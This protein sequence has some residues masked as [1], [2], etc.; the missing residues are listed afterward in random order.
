ML[1]QGQDAGTLPRG[2]RERG[3]RCLAPRAP[4]GGSAMLQKRTG[5]HNALFD[6]C[7]LFRALGQSDRALL[8][9]RA[10]RAR[11]AAGTPVF[12]MGDPGDSMMVIVAGGVRISLPTKAGRD[13]I[14]SDLKAGEVFGEVALLDGLPRSAAAT[15][16]TNCELLLLRRED[17]IPFL[18]SQPDSCL[19]LVALLCG[20]LRQADERMTDIGLS[21]L[22]ARLAKT[23]LSRT[24]DGTGAASRIGVSQ[25]DLAGMVGSSRES[26]NRTLR[27][28]H[29][30]GLLELKDGWITILGRDALAALA[31]CA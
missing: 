18:R 16:L 20:R 14:L 4:G 12:Q 19:A 24:S 7:F 31:A 9:A 13:I 1:F 22:P 8:A 6:R 26:V 11:Y 28:W 2:A 25:S 15:A 10:V 30:Q 27:Q 23:I 3:Q 17:V 5:Q 21:H 29:Q